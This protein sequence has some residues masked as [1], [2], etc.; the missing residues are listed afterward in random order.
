M[1]KE[2][3]RGDIWFV[4]WSPGRGS[5]QAGMRPAMIIQ[6]D[7]ANLNPHYPNTI[8]LTISTKGKAVPFHVSVNPSEENGLKETSFVKCEQILTISKV[9]LIRCVGRLENERLET[10]A[11]AIRRV[12]EV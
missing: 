7:A 3:R 6:T 1:Y 2:V 5:E 9:R 4:D 10:V 11:A 12:L 8:V